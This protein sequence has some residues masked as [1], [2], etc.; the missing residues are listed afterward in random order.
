[1]KGKPFALVGVNI[2]GHDPK[3]LKA[4]MD[5]ERLA[6][7]SFTDTRDGEGL[8]VIASAWNLYGTPM[9]F[10]LDHTGVIRYRRVGYQDTTA[11]DGLL[12]KLIAEAEASDKKEK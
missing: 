8:G 11:I 5:A 9:V 7:R 3:A 6:F 1:M 4:V 12:T 10:V 2:N